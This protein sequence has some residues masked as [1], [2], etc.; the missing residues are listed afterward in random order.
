MNESN[1]YDLTSSEGSI[2]IEIVAQALPITPEA[3]ERDRQ[4]R[5]RMPSGRHT[6]IEPPIAPPATSR[7]LKNERS[8]C[9]C[10][11]RV[12]SVEGGEASLT[13]VE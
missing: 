10:P 3:L 4:R 13:T 8:K 6:N 11:D 1:E 7:P 5:L 2:L 12:D 9:R